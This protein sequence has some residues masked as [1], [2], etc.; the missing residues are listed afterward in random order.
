MI[1]HVGNRRREEN[2]SVISHRTQAL[3]RALCKQEL[4]KS[5]TRGPGSPAGEP[6]GFQRGARVP[7]RYPDILPPPS[8]PCTRPP[9]DGMGACALGAHPAGGAPAA[10]LP[11]S[12][13]TKMT[14]CTAVVKWRYS[15]ASPSS[16]SAPPRWAPDALRGSLAFRAAQLPLC[17]MARLGLRLGSPPARPPGAPRQS[18]LPRAQRDARVP[19]GVPS[20]LHIASPGAQEAGRG[21]GEAAPRARS[22]VG[23]VS[24]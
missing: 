13:P 18:L 3:C 14:T 16:P 6:L 24:T 11:S 20:R 1:S 4:G 17:P 5:E 2:T 7:R 10:G 23:P 9:G 12:E 19:G 15:C 8:A 22:L 21:Q